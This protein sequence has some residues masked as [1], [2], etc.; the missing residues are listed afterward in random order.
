MKIKLLIGM[1]V[2]AI[3]I[4]GCSASAPATAAEEKNFKE[5]SKS[6]PP[7]AGPKGPPAG[8]KSGPG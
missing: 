4:G 1:L 8:A 3:A 2:A 7:E 5:P 6:P